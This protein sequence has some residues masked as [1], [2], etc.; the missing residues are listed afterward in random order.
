[1]DPDEPSR[2]S[3]CSALLGGAPY[4]SI[5]D[6]KNEREPTPDETVGIV[7]WNSLSEVERAAWLAR[8]GIAVPA[9]AWAAFTRFGDIERQP[10]S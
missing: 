8:V 3:D 9:D 2:D 6:M 10:R 5:E 1:V 7:W 4:A